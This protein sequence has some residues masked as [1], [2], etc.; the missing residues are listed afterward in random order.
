MEKH[1]EVLSSDDFL[2]RG[3]FEAG[4]DKAAEYIAAEFQRYGL[5]T[6]NGSDSFVVPYTLYQYTWEKNSSLT[7]VNDNG[8]T[9]IPNDRMAPIQV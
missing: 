3:T 8:S 5:Q 2:G 1:V 9:V 6:V 7:I 4:L